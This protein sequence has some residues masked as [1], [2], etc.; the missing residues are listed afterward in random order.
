LKIC[1]R[2]RGQRARFLPQR[3]QKTGQGRGFTQGT[4]GIVITPAIGDDATVAEIAVKFKR[5]EGQ[6]GELRDQA[7]R[8]FLRHQIFAVAQARGAVIFLGEQLC[9][10]HH[11]AF[12]PLCAVKRKW[13]RIWALKNSPLEKARRICS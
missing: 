9:L 6:G 7:A 10:A 13:S 3:Q 1:R 4:P 2:Q 5:L 12:K 8:F 11:T